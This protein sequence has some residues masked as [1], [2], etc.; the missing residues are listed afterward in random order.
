MTQEQAF[1]KAAQ[2]LE[3]LHNELDGYFDDFAELDNNGEN[4]LASD[5]QT[6]CR[7][8]VQRIAEIK[9]EHNLKP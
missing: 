6:L 8:T 7:E 9:R 4:Q 1:K 5:M 2:L 3:Q